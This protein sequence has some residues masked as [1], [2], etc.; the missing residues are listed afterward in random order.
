MAVRGAA[1]GIRAG[2]TG[3]LV[4]GPGTAVWSCDVRS[5]NKRRRTRAA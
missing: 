4:A 1:A 2:L 3:S 5:S